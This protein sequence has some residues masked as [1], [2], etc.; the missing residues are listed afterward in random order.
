M[1]RAKYWQVQDKRL[2]IDANLL[3]YNRVKNLPT[4]GFLTR[5]FSGTESQAVRIHQYG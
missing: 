1:P 2:A 5:H 4:H 3:I